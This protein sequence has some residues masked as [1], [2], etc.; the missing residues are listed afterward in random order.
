M[1]DFIGLIACMIVCHG[2][3]LLALPLLSPQ[4]SILS[5]RLA[6]LASIGFTTAAHA[7][8]LCPLFHSPQAAWPCLPSSAS[9]WAPR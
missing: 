4:P 2:W 3:V 7:A 8:P 9:P 5:G 6:M 1:L